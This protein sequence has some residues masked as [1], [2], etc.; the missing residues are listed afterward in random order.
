M[1]K[2]ENAHVYVVYTKS[3]RVAVTQI[4]TYYELLDKN[5]QQL[6]NVLQCKFF[7]HHLVTVTGTHQHD[8]HVHVHL[9]LLSKINV[10][11]CICYV[12]LCKFRSLQAMVIISDIYML[13]G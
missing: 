10:Y 9:V 6:C 4:F 7:L 12:S 3:S 8:M 5:S 11:Y 13:I 1:G 2:K